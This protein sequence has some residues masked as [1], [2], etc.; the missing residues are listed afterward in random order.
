ML[1]VD[2]F[3]SLFRSADKKQFELLPP[4]VKRVLIV[5]DLEGDEQERYVEAV[6]KLLKVLGKCE[7]V[8]LTG[9]EYAEVDELLDREREIDPDLIVGYRN[10]KS[11]AWR[12]PFSLGSFL[13]VLTQ[14]SFTPVLVVPNPHE[15]PDLGWKDS[16]TDSV[17]VVADHL[18]GDDALVNWGVRMTRDQGTLWL[19]HVED[20]QTFNRYIDTI[21]KI[22]TLDTEVA[23]EEILE[24]LLKEPNDYIDTCRSAIEAGEVPIAVKSLVKTGHRVSDYKLLAEEHSVDILIF[25]SRDEDQVAMHG[26]AYP[27]AVELRNVP[28]LL[29]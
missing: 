28:L 25:H 22:P 21:G 2:E 8:Y 27:L 3:E 11:R 29:I 15:V 13:N 12:W 9:S 23:R 1:R 18:T 4:A 6:K 7:W 26:A 17:M 16:D 10:L 19:T 5:S 14:K 20:D 24:Q